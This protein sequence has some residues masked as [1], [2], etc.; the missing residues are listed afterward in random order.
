L[1]PGNPYFGWDNEKVDD[2]I[3]AMAIAAS[4]GPIPFGG[5]SSI[6]M[7]YGGRTD[8]EAHRG[9]YERAFDEF[10]HC[11]SSTMDRHFPHEREKVSFFFD[12]NENKEWIGILN[13]AIKKAKKRDGRIA[14]KYVLIDGKSPRGMPCQAAD[15]FA[16]V[17]RQLQETIF[18][19]GSFQKSRLLDIIVSRVA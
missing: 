4:S 11:F 12:D 9:S 6:K 19:T 3:H 2:F 1:R 18:E 15:L 14:Y 8:K 7:L 16:Y 13:R 5:F 10:F 17:D